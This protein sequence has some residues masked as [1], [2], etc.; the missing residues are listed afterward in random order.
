MKKETA[1]IVQLIREWDLLV[2]RDTVL[3]RRRLTDGLQTVQLILPVGFLNQALKDLHD[4]NGH[5]GRDH[6]L[7]SVRSRFYWPF[8]ATHIEK[9]VAHCGRRIRRKA[10]DPPRALMK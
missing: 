4:D 1:K 2:I 8:M 10:S 3:L 6:T 9:Y 7:D 5:P